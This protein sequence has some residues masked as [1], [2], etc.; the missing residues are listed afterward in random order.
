[1]NSQILKLQREI[2]LRYKKIEDIKNQCP[3]NDV[4]G[5]YKGNTGNWCKDDDSYWIEAECQ[6]CG[7][8][9]NIDSEDPLYKTFKFRKKI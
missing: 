7:K 8:R 1:M 9:F 6:D 4:I 5:Q 2:S 3:H